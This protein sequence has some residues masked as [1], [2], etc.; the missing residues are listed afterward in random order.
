[1]TSSPPR[2]GIAAAIN[3]NGGNDDAAM[4]FPSIQYEPDYEPIHIIRTVH[5]D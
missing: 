2:G 4:Q 5:P 1:M 3:N